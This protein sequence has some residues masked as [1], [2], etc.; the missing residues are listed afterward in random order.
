M[1][2]RAMARF[3][4]LNAPT[5]V[6]ESKGKEDSEDI[7]VEAV[8]SVIA[9]GASSFQ[10]DNQGLPQGSSSVS[11]PSPSYN[12]PPTE[13]AQALNRSLAAEL[14]QA[15]SPFLPTRIK[16]P[17]ESGTAVSM[18]AL[19]LLGGI[20]LTLPLFSEKCLRCGP[21]LYS[22]NLIPCLAILRGTCKIP[23]VATV[24]VHTCSSMRPSRK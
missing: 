6:M 7:P 13:N 12:L 23:N 11:P 14:I 20:T 4:A 17:Q 5:Q 18:I 15:G 9:S 21:T 8:A 16:Y 10:R 3:S 24:R 19:F 1:Q 22:P 2:R